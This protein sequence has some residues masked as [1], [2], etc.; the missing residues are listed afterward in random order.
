M[1]DNVN[2]DELEDL[3]DDMDDMAYETN[4]M[5]EMMNRNYGLDVNE[6]DLEE[7]F[8]DLDN[9]LFQEMMVNN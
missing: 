9:E 1:F 7:E 8:R 5:N 6:D 2:I 4:Y 3:K